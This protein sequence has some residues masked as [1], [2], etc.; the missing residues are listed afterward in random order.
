MNLVSPK[1]IK[2][3]R[4]YFT[5]FDRVSYSQLVLSAAELESIRH[6]IERKLKLLVL[7]KGHVIIAASHLLESELAREVL[8]PHP[9]LFSN[10]VIVPALRVEFKGFKIR[11]N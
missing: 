10:G 8:F 9:R 2:A 4:V 3:S 1:S 6:N 5:E 11:Q 7:I